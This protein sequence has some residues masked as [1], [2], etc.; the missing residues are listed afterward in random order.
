MKEEQAKEAAQVLGGLIKRLLN[1]SER[2]RK[3]WRLFFT[4]S[5]VTIT[6]TL[7]GIYDDIQPVLSFNDLVMLTLVSALLA[8]QLGMFYT[9]SKITL[10]ILSL[11]PSMNRPA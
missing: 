10:E 9:R 8:I 1:T 7:F 4:S 6:A 5:V 2:H 11:Y 3:G